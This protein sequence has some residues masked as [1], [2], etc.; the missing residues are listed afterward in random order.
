[1][2]STFNDIRSAIEGRIA[3]EMALSP[4]YP[5][6]YQNVPFT[7]PNNLPW[8]QVFLS[9][10][11]NNYATLSAPTTGFNAQNGVLT[12]N[13]FTPVGAGAAANFTIVERL[14]DLFDRKT[15]S[16][17][18]FDASDGPIVLEASTPQ[19]VASPPSTSPARDAFFQ[20]QLSITFTCYVD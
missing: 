3:T 20:S 1:M 12:F 4:S 10:S 15:I 17:I 7:P 2:S 9:F 6:A 16:S 13:V 18:I 8:I 5:V 11:S 14:K 19:S